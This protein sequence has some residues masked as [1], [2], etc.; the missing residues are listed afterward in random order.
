[1][2]LLLEAIDVH[3]SFS[4]PEK[5]DLLKGISL[6]VKKKCSIAIMGASGEGKTTLLHILGTLESF[7]KGQI[8]IN[9]NNIAKIDKPY[10]RNNFIGFIFQ[11]HNLLDDL[12]SLD[13]VLM[14]ARI[15][16]KK[17]IKKQEGLKLLKMVHLEHKA[18]YPIKLLSGGERQRVAIA[19]AFCNHPKLI[20]A[21]E[22]SGNL[23]HENSQIV[24]Q[25]LL[26]CVK[27]EE[28]TLIVVTHDESLATLCEE[29]YILQ[30]GI[31]I[32]RK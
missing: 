15:G 6:K 5:I 28:K 27:K 20:L 22:P 8:V 17:T 4:F 31:L 7:D 24:H 2:S 3:K 19:R 11:F 13:N 23:D 30:S 10:F 16:R 12:T 14:P 32:K 21:D 1:M 25:L 26:D 9:D 18:N 29:I